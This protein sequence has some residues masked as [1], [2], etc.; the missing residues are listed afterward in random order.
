MGQLPCADQRHE[1][2]SLQ[3]GGEAWG[4]LADGTR[5]T[6]EGPACLYLASAPWGGLA[7]LPDGKSGTW[8]QFSRPRLPLCFGKVKVKLLSRVRLFVTPWTGVYQASPAMGFSRQEY[9]SGVPLP[10]PEDLPNP[11]LEPRSPILQADALPSEPPG[12]PLCFGPEAKNTTVTQ[13]QESV[14]AG[15]AFWDPPPKRV[16]GV[17]T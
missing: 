17:G 3:G 12:K 15:L 5:R 9:W 14:P 4:A 16:E 6:P 2:L 10:S 8:G 11:G 7:R 1:V 13:G